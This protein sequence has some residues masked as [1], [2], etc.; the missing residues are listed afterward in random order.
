MVEEK[1]HPNYVVGA[2]FI[3]SLPVIVTGEARRKC[4]SRQIASGLRN[5]FGRRVHSDILIRATF[6]QKRQ[7]VGTIPASYVE[8]PEITVKLHQNVRQLCVYG[9]MVH[10]VV[11]F[12]RVEDIAA[13][14]ARVN[15]VL[16]E[17]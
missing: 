4:G 5:R 17:G 16:G 14:K 11:T 12:E 1:P 15:F 2:S 9:A 13:V 6:Q 8:H 3:Q 10:D 7:D